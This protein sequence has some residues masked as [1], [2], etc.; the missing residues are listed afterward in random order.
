M[1]KKTIFNCF[2]LSLMLICSSIYADNIG[3]T[4]AGTSSN[5]IGNNNG[6]NLYG[7][8]YRSVNGGTLVTAF[9]NGHNNWNGTDT[10]V[11]LI[12]DDTGGYPYSLIAESAEI[13]INTS[14][15]T[16]WSASI[17][18]TISAA[19]D[20]WIFVRNKT[21]DAS[22]VRIHNDGNIITGY[23]TSDPTPSN[24]LFADGATSNNNSEYSMYISYTAGGGGGG[25]IQIRRR[26]I[27]NI[28]RNE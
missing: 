11:I 27:S 22:S 8:K 15:Y 2:I 1:N 16:W 5:T 6:T 26:V 24:N 21:I 7:S 13:E 10:V 9:I 14:T 19:T 20:Y 12:Y 28:R 23:R 18:G 17:T 3:Y 4:T 25:G